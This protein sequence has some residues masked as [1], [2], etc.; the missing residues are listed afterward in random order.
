MPPLNN[1]SAT[2][3]SASEPGSEMAVVTEALGT[4]TGAA[5]VLAML[6]ADIAL[7]RPRLMPF[8]WPLITGVLADCEVKFTGPS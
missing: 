4:R 1:M 6:G 8:G 3:T 5:T 7:T 2:P